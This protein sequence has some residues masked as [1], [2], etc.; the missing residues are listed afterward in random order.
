[1]TKLCWR[2]QDVSLVR[3]M[4]LK[5][6]DSEMIFPQPKIWQRVTPSPQEVHICGLQQKE[7][8]IQWN[9]VT[10]VDTV[11]WFVEEIF[12]L[13]RC[14]PSL[15]TFKI[16]RAKGLGGSILFHETMTSSSS[17]IP[18][19]HRHLRTLVYGGYDA[20]LFLSRVELPGLVDFSCNPKSLPNIL[21]QE[22]QMIF[23]H[24]FERCGSRLISLA[25]EDMSFTFDALK[26][27]LS[28]VPSL[29]KLRMGCSIPNLK[30]PVYRQTDEILLQFLE[31]LTETTLSHPSHEFLPHLSELDWR[32]VTSGLP[33]KRISNLFGM[34]EGL[35]NSHQR[36]FKV[37]RVY[38][39]VLP[40]DIPYE[41][42]P[43]LFA[44]K[45]APGMLIEYYHDRRCIVKKALGKH[46]R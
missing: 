29:T 13:F 39:R 14:A 46:R 36:P 33:W 35:H 30:D 45:G 26:S 12:E 32:I 25:L 38:S 19:I 27:L 17:H 2:V 20:I 9:H 7:L 8:N 10:Y 31:Y 41:I 11:C 18:F 22:D 16:A 21:P 43:D 44:P 37:L 24:F 40:E 34:P 5:D 4:Y 42:I 6:H 3:R 23:Q 15:E 28:S 1:M